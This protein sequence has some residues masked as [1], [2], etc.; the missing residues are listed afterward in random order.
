MGRNQ[1]DSLSLYAFGLVGCSKFICGMRDAVSVCL[2]LNLLV[3]RSVDPDLE[4][5]AR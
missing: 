1:L 2:F 4:T 3:M 5:S